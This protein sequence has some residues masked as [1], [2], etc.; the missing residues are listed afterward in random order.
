MLHTISAAGIGGAGSQIIDKV[1]RNNINTVA[2][3]STEIDTVG[4]DH[5]SGLIYLGKEGCGK[6]RS[7]GKKLVKNQASQ[8]I[9]RLA[10]LCGDA[11]LVFIIGATSG[12]TGSGS[13]PI[14]SDLLRSYYKSQKRDVKIIAIGI[15]PDA[16]EDVRALSNAIETVKELSGLGIPYM[17]YDNDTVQGSLINKYTTINNS[18]VEDIM[19]LR[20]DYNLPT[21]YGSMD[22]RDSS[23][24]LKVPGLMTVNKISGFKK[25][26][27][28]QKSFD[29][30]ILKSIKESY[31]VQLQKDKVIGRIGLIVS[32]TEEMLDSFDKGISA[33]QDELGKAS[34]IY[35]HIN[36][37]EDEKEVSIITILTGL[38]V[39]DSRL[40]DMAYAIE[41]A[42][43]KVLKQ[44]KSSINDLSATADWLRDKD[45]EDEEDDVELFEE[46]LNKW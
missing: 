41:A 37:V 2:V 13:L 36:I 4:V 18:I 20:G 15:L 10:E 8:F 27:L 34:E 16:S 43:E 24:L 44:S 30:L 7:E 11:S 42:K 40:E 25:T 6:I 35:T 17:L 39:P 26:T 9:P 5:S 32:L 45:E 31:N 12:G 33:V 1:A 46:S 21:V 22:V 14:T 29:S 38:S 28:D 23:N 19:V 3:N